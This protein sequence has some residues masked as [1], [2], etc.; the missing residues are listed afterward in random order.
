VF[1]FLDELLKSVD[2]GRSRANTFETDLPI[3][4]RSRDRDA[5]IML[6]FRADVAERAPIQ[7]A[8]DPM[9]RHSNGTS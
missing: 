5:E 7:W 4:G 1:A 3:I 8:R 9:F 6:T 2:V